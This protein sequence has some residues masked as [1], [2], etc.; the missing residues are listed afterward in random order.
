M[1]EDEERKLR[2]IIEKKWPAHLPEL[3]VAINTGLRKGS[4][5]ALRWDMVDWKSRELHIPNTEVKNGEALHVPLN[6]AAIAALKVTFGAGDDMGRVFKSKRTGDPL[7]NGRHWFDNAILDAKI[8]NFH[9]QLHPRFVYQRVPSQSPV[10]FVPPIPGGKK[11]R[12]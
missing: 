5:Y 4:Q 2:E 6:A 8:K 11:H 9:F 1:T 7:E 10:Q 3:D 12:P